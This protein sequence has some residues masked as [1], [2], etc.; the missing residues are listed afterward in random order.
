MVCERPKHAGAKMRKPLEASILTND[1][2][3]GLLAKIRRLQQ[4]SKKSD[5]D[6]VR[7]AMDLSIDLAPY[8]NA[9]LVSELPETAWRRDPGIFDVY[10]RKSMPRERIVTIAGAGVPDHVVASDWER[11]PS[12]TS[13][14]ADDVAED[15]GARGFCYFKLVAEASK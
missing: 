11:M 7:E 9:R 6:S 15:I 13:Q 8:F 10:R 14:I 4:L 1:L 5:Q 2:P 12:G 3:A